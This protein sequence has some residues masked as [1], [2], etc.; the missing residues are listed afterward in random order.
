M[1]DTSALVAALVRTHEHHSRARAELPAAV[2]LPVIVVAE[3]YSI[4]RRVF[5]QSARVAA[6]L[7]APWSHPDA[8]IPTSPTVMATALGRAVELDLAGN[9]HDALIALACVESD[10]PIVTLD[11]RQHQI[12]LALGARSTYLLA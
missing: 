11:S 12:A 10:V 5:G 6:G 4:L 3:T 1:M 8:L 7:L 9:I 2:S